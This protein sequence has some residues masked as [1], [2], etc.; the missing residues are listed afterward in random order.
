M[1]EKITS[2][3]LTFDL[4][5]CKPAQENLA[6]RLGE[7]LPV[8][9]RA[10]GFRVLMMDSREIDETHVA[11][12]VLLQEGHF[13]VHFYPELRYAACEFYLCV[14]GAK[15][16]RIFKELKKLL[17]PEKTRT[18]YLKRGDFGKE[19]DMKPRVKTRFA[20]LRKI[21]NTGA[22]MISCLKTNKKP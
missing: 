22:K 3:H 21:K 13:T 14:P 11:A 1:D 10:D 20:P 2:R 6:D 7:D 9:L 19:P 16:E 4:Y 15:P 8:L 5:A 12:M 17:R 18:T